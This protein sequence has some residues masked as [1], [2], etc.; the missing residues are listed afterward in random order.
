L[1]WRGIVRLIRLAGIRALLVWALPGCARAAYDPATLS[2]AYSVNVSG[3]GRVVSLV[4][5]DWLCREAIAIKGTA[6]HWARWT[7]AEDKT[8]ACPLTAILGVG[9]PAAP[10]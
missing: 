8:V 7:E 9:A 6:S 4:P 3:L 1:N 2:W 5:N 10:H